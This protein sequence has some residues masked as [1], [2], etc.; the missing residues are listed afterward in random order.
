[1]LHRL[2]D[3]L[4]VFG[5]VVERRRDLLRLLHSAAG[6]ASAPGTILSTDKSPGLPAISPGRHT[7]LVD[8]IDAGDRRDGGALV[9]QQEALGSHPGAS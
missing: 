1:L 8:L 3:F 9:A 4:D 6:R 7:S 5:E 2:D